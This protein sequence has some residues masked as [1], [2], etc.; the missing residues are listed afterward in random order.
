MPAWKAE[1]LRI[2]GFGPSAANEPIEALWSTI[3]GSPPEQIEQRP[4]EGF[5]TAAGPFE[6]GILHLAYTPSR[7]DWIWSPSAGNPTASYTEISSIGDYAKS[8]STFA[9][10]SKDWLARKPSLN[11]LAWG[12]VLLLPAADKED[13]Y[14]KLSGFLPSLKVDPTGSADLM[15]QINR[16]RNSKIIEG[17]RIIRLS[18]WSVAVIQSLSMQLT[19]TSGVA[20]ATATAGATGPTFSACR[21]QVDI[22]SAPDRQELLEADRVIQLLDE[23]ILLANEIS[24]HGDIP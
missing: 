21:L 14:E 3:A 1:S 9:K 16:P 6:G 15:Y 19:L 10:I 11:R 13:G 8:T 20:A 2:T 5:S 24:T 12:G 7:T 23:F 4:K 22:N 18:T 17:L